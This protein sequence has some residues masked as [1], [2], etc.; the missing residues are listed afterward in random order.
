MLDHDHFDWDAVSTSGG[1]N[2]KIFVSVQGTLASPAL[3]IQGSTILN[4]D[5][6]GIHFGGGSGVQVLGNG[7]TDFFERLGEASAEK[8]LSTVHAGYLTKGDGH[9]FLSKSPSIY[10]LY[11]ETGRREYQP[12]GPTAAEGGSS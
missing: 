2:A 9:A 7:R 10:S 5:L 8:N 3:T 1:P 4:G 12:A 6:D 11:Y